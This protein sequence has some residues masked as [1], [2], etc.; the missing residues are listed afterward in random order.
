VSE[1]RRPPRFPPAG[2]ERAHL[3]EKVALWA[4][5]GALVVAGILWLTGEIAG[6]L[7]GGAWP[8]TRLSEMGHVLVRFHAHAGDPA[9]AWPTPE[10]RLIPGPVSFYATLSTRRSRRCS[11][12]SPPRRYSCCDA[13]SVKLDPAT[14]GHAGHARATSALCASARRSPGD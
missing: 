4:L 12:R 8:G 6:R 11:S 3:L 14:P 13:A 2:E 5:A 1:E 9:A 10:R 7:F